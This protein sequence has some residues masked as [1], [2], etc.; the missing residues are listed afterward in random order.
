MDAKSWFR[1]ALGRGVTSEDRKVLPDGVWVKCGGC[2]EILYRDDYEKNQWVCSDCNHHGGI[3]APEY[4]A[5][6]TDGGF[7]E[8]IAADLVSGDALGFVDSKEY[9]DR[10]RAAQTK[11]GMKEAVITGRAM[12]DGVDCAVA[13]MD[14]RFIGGSMGSVV[15]EKI[16]RAMRLGL[17]ERIPVVTVAR[18]GGARMQEGILSL[19]Q[20]VKT[21]AVVARLGENKVPYVS[22]LTNPT[23][24]GVMAS[25]ASL[26]DV[27]ISEP[28]ALLGFAGPRVIRD[29]IKAEL[30]E[31]FQSAEF[32]LEHGMIDMI[33]H[34]KDMRSVVGSVLRHLTAAPPV[35][36]E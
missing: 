28:G 2:G 9:P 33:V 35:E 5:L 24:A 26:G 15:G 11:S 14:F 22:I 36:T 10:I 31:G 30:P 4:L 29:T 34:R 6:L 32:F 1:K 20:L 12:I 7:T 27:I 23:M 3:G 13:V 8:E 21:S 16:A 18:S 25:W 19:M 17:Q